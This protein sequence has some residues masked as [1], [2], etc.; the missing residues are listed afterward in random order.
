MS[1]FLN[2]V[3]EGVKIDMIVAHAGENREKSVQ[4]LLIC[5]SGCVIKWSS[6]DALRKP[7]SKRR[8]S[9]EF[10]HTKSFLHSP[11]A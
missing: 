6:V 4:M 7:H 2:R 5:A 3:V 11:A 10:C 9:I 8:L 1:N